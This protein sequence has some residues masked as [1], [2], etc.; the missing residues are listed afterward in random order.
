M[1]TFGNSDGPGISVLGDSI[2]T[3]A[4][5]IPEGWR[6]H[7]GG[8]AKVPDVERP[9]DTWWGRVI[10]GLDGHLVANASFS[11]SVMEGFGFPAGCSAERIAALAGPEGELPDVVIVYLG[12]N[13]YGWAGGRNQVMGHSL[14]ASARPEDLGEPYEVEPV[15]APDAV[16]RFERAYRHALAQVRERFPEALTWCVTLCPGAVAGDADAVYKW[17]IRGVD[18]DEY[19]R[20]IRRAAEAEGARVA[21]L[22]A[23]GVDVDTVDGAHPTA[24]GMRQLAGMCLAQMAGLPADRSVVADLAGARTSRR[25]CARESC[26][27]CPYDDTVPTRWTIA[28]HPVPVPKR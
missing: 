21:D 16:D 8:E 5:W 28:C 18:L 22:R 19:N 1:T 11:G 6:V 25:T 24:L 10:C 7:Y 17:C 14:S 13:D 23:F 3:L 27:G 4:G 2:S 26:V 12:I 9:E 20:A 15:A